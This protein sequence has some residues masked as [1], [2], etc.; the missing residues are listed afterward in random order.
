M[1]D[2]HPN[3]SEVESE[4]GITLIEKP[5]AQYDAVILAVAHNE[6]KN[7]NIEGTA[8]NSSLIYDLKGVWD[9]DTVDKRL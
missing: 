8:K 3:K 4:Y 5:V 9:Q 2:P 7:F 1:Y 6:F